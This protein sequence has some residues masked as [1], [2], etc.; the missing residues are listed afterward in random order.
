[1]D[2][3]WGILLFQSL[4]T[5][6]AAVGASSGFWLY[7]ESRRN[8]GRNTRKLLMGIAH[9]RIVTLCMRYISRG[10]ILQEEYENLH[11]FL[12]KPYM[13]MGGNGTAIRLMKEVDL[14]PI[15]NQKRHIEEKTK[16]KGDIDVTR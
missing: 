16:P 1:M 8:T 9:D 15:F 3:H 4:I 11:D 2:I 14:L 10:Y 6:L 12:Y 7:L 5:V 13:E